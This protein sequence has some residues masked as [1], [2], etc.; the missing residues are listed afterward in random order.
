MTKR[1]LPANCECCNEHYRRYSTESAACLTDDK[2]TI[3]FNAE[4]VIVASQRRHS[5]CAF[6]NPE[7]PFGTLFT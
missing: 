1:E 5:E 4:D 6:D 7:V 2:I 3:W